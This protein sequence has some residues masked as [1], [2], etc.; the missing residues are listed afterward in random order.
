MDTSNS[1]KETR[2]AWPVLGF[3]ERFEQIV[4]LILTLLIAIV[5]ITAL[6]HLVFRIVLLIMLNVVD[7]ANQTVFQ[8]IFG[9]IMTVLI[10]LEF[11]HSVIAVL[12]RH[13]NIV[14]VR[15]VVLIALLALVRKFIIIDASHVEAL[16][17]IGLALATLA[18][19]CVYWLIREQE[20]R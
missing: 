11:K 15:T 8:T 12:E 20:R 16:T 1:W 4:S 9:M 13:N 14:Q 7:P 5:I 18:L 17:L 3:Y 2:Q 10:A 6:A 19:G